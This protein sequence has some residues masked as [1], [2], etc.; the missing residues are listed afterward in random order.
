MNH[1]L[2]NVNSIIGYRRDENI[3]Y[4]NVIWSGGSKSWEYS[5][6][7]ES[8]TNISKLI[9]KLETSI[10]NLIIE[11]N[12]EEE[13]KQK[14]QLRDLIKK[15]SLQ[16]KITHNRK[17]NEDNFYQSNLRS[18]H[19]Q[20]KSYD[21]LNI[22]IVDK[23]DKQN[24]KPHIFSNRNDM[25]FVNKRVKT[26]IIN[27]NMRDKNYTEYVTQKRY[28]EISLSKK[29]IGFIQKKEHVKQHVTNKLT[30]IHESN[31]IAY[32]NDIVDVETNELLDRD[33]FR[34]EKI[35]ANDVLY[36]FLF[37]VF[38]NP[39]IAEFSIFRLSL[40]NSVP[41]LLKTIEQMN[42]NRYTL[43]DDNEPDYNLV[44]LTSN[45]HIK[46]FRGMSADFIMLKIKKC[47]FNI[48]N[49]YDD[50][51][52]EKTMSDNFYWSKESLSFNSIITNEIIFDIERFKIAKFQKFFIFTDKNDLVLQQLGVLMLKSYKGVYDNALLNTAYIFINENYLEFVQSLPTLYHLKMQTCKFIVI[53]PKIKDMHYQS[54]VIY[55]DGGIIT[56]TIEILEQILDLPFLNTIV[57]SLKDV[58]CRWAC[59]ITS[60]LYVEYKDFVLLHKDKLKHGEMFQVLKWLETCVKET[61]IIDTKTFLKTLEKEFIKEYRMFFILNI[62]VCDDFMITPEAL[63]K[64][65]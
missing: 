4:L 24:E 5:Y 39:Q 43:V 48:P 26:D 65:I 55:P 56:L 8:H 7:I 37:S 29:E 59:K 9:C 52:F 31:H 38:Q 20:H 3:D 22:Q 27:N 13:E 21:D 61:N 10:S 34:A 25:N 44:L 28:Y 2:K 36:T 63:I 1:K 54:Y 50:L 60:K 15:S 58:N 64:L 46:Q 19:M 42:K 30:L 49:K 23:K 17:A 35:V 11:R 51:I 45:K 12:N 57:N 40:Y 41:S 47:A 33:I 32:F 18:N 16:K 53:N 14:K 6:N 62:D